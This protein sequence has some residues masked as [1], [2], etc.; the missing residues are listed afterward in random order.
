MDAVFKARKFPD[1]VKVR[2]N[3]ERVRAEHKT[4]Y[5]DIQTSYARNRDEYEASAR[6]WMK[7]MLDGRA[8]EWLDK[9]GRSQDLV[10][11]PSQTMRKWWILAGRL[12]V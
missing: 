6:W 9:D 2:E 12:R 7:M 11:M 4:Q 8:M 1:P 5:D 10:D 3:D